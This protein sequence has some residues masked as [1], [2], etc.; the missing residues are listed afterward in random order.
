MSGSV[1]GSWFSLFEG[2]PK[3]SMK[4]IDLSALNSN[5]SEAGPVLEKM[6]LLSQ[7]RIEGLVS[8]RQVVSTGS[9]SGPLL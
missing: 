1:V 3:L 6:V 7:R 9:I 5:G 4:G 8:S 2:D